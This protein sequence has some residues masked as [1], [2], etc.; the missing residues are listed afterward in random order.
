MVIQPD[1][2]DA[3]ERGYHMRPF[4]AVGAR[5]RYGAGQSATHWFA[6]RPLPVSSACPPQLPQTDALHPARLMARERPNPLHSVKIGHPFRP[7]ETA[8]AAR[9]TSSFNGGASTS[10]ALGK[11]RAPP[12][13]QMTDCPSQARPP[14]PNAPEEGHS[15][16]FHIRQPPVNC[17]RTPPPA[18]VVWARQEGS[19]TVDRA[20]VPIKQGS[21]ADPHL[22][23]PLPSSH[24]PCYSLTDPSA[25][26]RFACLTVACD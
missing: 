6:S 26:C 3:F 8:R 24:L 17:S 2:T 12:L 23:R 15:P 1:S 18:V 13:Y 10:G 25:T 4:L 21:P 16:V 14:R 5:E 7:A 20:V 22:P 9:D 19:Q 11:Q